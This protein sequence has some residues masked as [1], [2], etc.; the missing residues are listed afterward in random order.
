MTALGPALASSST[1]WV[2][3]P[4]GAHDETPPEKSRSI[5]L[6]P[7]SIS[8]DEEERYYAGFSNGALWPLYHDAI[9]TPTF[10]TDWWDAYVEVNQR[11]ADAASAAA[12]A[13]ATVW[14]HDYQLQLVPQML[15]R[16]RP[17]LRIGFFLHIPFPAQELFLRLPWRSALIEGLL[18]ADVVGFQTAVG[19]QNFRAVAGR[20]LGCTLDG[21]TIDRDGRRV[22]ADSFPIGIDAAAVSTMARAPATIARAAQIRHQLGDP[23]TVLLGVDR[24]DYTKGI[25]ARLQA[26]EE[27]L[28]EQRL[29]PGQTVMVQI[30]QPSRADAPGYADIRR[31]VNERVGRINGAYSSLHKAVVKYLHHGQST[32]ELIALYTIA[33]VMLVTPFRDG[34]NLVAKEYVAARTD[35]T[36]LLI[37]SEFA[38]AAHQLKDAVHVNPFD[39]EGL[40]DAIDAAVHRPPPDAAARMARMF[41]QV[42]DHDATEWAT[43]FLAALDRA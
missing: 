30:A 39:I 34:M 35:H 37:L 21:A 14:V 33:D 40:K 41:A 29:D 24:L 23:K 31:E 3:W 32:R 36:G 42:H 6:V 2:G 10:Q 13:G 16:Q 9:V 15:R 8:Q 38:G 28:R 26:L 27:L 25:N 7:V 17:D 18:G 19:A 12:V 4:G 22:L 43:G 11:F 5:R 1:T 20:L